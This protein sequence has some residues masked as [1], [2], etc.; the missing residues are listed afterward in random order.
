MKKSIFLARLS[1]A[2]SASSEITLSGF[3][4]LA[5][6]VGPAG[7]RGSACRRRV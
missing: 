4:L 1:T 6:A 2:S 5:G 3:L 7:T